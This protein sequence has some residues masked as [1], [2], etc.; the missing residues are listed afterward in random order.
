MQTVLTLNI[1]HI[2]ILNDITPEIDD[3]NVWVATRPCEFI[4]TTTAL[5]SLIAVKHFSFL[6]RNHRNIFIT[7]QAVIQAFRPVTMETTVVHQ[8]RPS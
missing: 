2:Q 6:D 1:R 4:A 8:P 7:S 3:A 5:L